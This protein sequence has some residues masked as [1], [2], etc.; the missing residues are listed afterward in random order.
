LTGAGAMKDWQASFVLSSS[1]FSR[2]FWGIVLTRNKQ[3][4]LLETFPK[5][6]GSL[7]FTLCD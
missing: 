1:F 6:E 7:K 4:F 5:K 2:I 3:N